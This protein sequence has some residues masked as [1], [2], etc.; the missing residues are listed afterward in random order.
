MKDIFG[1]PRETKNYTELQP[2]ESSMKE[3][4]KELGLQELE[5]SEEIQEL[6]KEETDRRPAHSSTK[7]GQ[8]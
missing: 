8:E 5:S 2:E 6:I 7:K 1:P 3:Y 4:L